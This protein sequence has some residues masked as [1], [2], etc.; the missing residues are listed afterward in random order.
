ME[1]DVGG[2]R[3]G[4]RD[5]FN[6]LWLITLNLMN[7]RISLRGAGEREVYILLNFR[8]W[9][10]RHKSHRASKLFARSQALWPGAEL[11]R[12]HARGFLALVS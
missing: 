5:A 4:S 3:I 9:T 2:K 12:C 10:D 8:N 6:S 1:C 11:N 7:K